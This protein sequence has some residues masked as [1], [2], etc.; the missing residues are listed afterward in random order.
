MGAFKS[1]IKTGSWGSSC[2]VYNKFGCSS[3]LVIYWM[4]RLVSVKI[5]HSSMCWIRNAVISYFVNECPFCV[6]CCSSFLKISIHHTILLLG[7]NKRLSANPS[8]NGLKRTKWCNPVFL[9]FFLKCNSFNKKKKSI[10]YFSAF[11]HFM[12]NS[13]LI[14][15]CTV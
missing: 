11:S 3:I 7:Q 12:W 1:C 8:R 6:H 4:V 10:D 2:M 15:A 13:F 5:I 14:L 9:S